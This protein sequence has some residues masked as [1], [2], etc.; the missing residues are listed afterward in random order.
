MINLIGN[1]SKVGIYD[2]YLSSFVHKFLLLIKPCWED[3]NLLLI[4]LILTLVTVTDSKLT[5]HSI[6]EIP[7]NFINFKTASFATS[8]HK[9]PAY[10]G[11]AN[12]NA[13]F[14]NIC[15]NPRPRVLKLEAEFRT[16]TPRYCSKFDLWRKFRVVNIRSR[17]Q[18]RR[19]DHLLMI[20]VLQWAAAC[21]NKT[22]TAA[23]TIELFL[24]VDLMLKTN[25]THGGPFSPRQCD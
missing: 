25:Y 1:F 9:S 22:T 23:W 20:D 5:L 4:L 16:H 15:V 18:R 21:V 24:T 12:T 7:Y 17:G 8:H 10:T 13:H 6:N 19:Q 11:H 14:T 3:E 2:I